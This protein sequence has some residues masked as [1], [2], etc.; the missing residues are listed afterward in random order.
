MEKF[1][2]GKAADAVK[3][4]VRKGKVVATVA[5]GL[6]ATTLASQPASAQ[7]HDHLPKTEETGGQRRMTAGSH[8]FDVTSKAYEGS[9][10]EQYSGDELCFHG[11]KLDL[12]FGMSSSAAIDYH[13]ANLF[14]DEA[15]G[16][17]VVDYTANKKVF[18]A[19]A[20]FKFDGTSFQKI[21]AHQVKA[22][23][24]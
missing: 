5:L 16:E 6:A 1:N 12:N 17:L 4:S 2:F 24:H 18:F 22:L 10:G 19:Q 7:T 20:I 14:Y 21:S 15:A 3:E 8:T 23:S 11:Q 13:I 9:W